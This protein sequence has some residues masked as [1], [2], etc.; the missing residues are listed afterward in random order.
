MTLAFLA[1]AYRYLLAGHVISVIL[2]MAGMILLPLIYAQHRAAGSELAEQAGFA[3]LDR[4]IVKGLVNPA[5]YAA[6]GFGILL[7][8][9][10]GAISWD[11]WWWR[12]KFAAVL[13]LSGY[14]GA[15][16]VWRRRLR[17]GSGRHGVRYYRAMTAI[18]VGFVVL[19]AA[20]VMIQPS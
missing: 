15:L 14:H 8:L 13:L 5:M 18:P 6:W 11:A 4:T 16:S 1:P 9:T 3:A 17:D 20:L 12:T 2:W 7:I 10:P 19:I